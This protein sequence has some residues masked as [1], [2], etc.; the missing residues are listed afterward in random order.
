VVLA[1]ADAA[2]LLLAAQ[3]MPP[4]LAEPSKSSPLAGPLKETPRAFG[5]LPAVAL[6]LAAVQE[7]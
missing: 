1:D 6:R 7:A 5:A 3:Q 4:A 2:E